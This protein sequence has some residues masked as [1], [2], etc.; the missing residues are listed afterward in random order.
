[1]TYRRPLPE[2]TLAAFASAVVTVFQP[3]PA[4]TVTVANGVAVG[5]FQR[6]ASWPVP[7]ARV[8]T[9]LMLSRL[10]GSNASQSP[11]PNEVTAPLADA[12]S[13]STVVMP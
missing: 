11:V 12:V 7:E 9:L 3:V 2:G 4:G 5:L 8:V 13:S 1:M 10:T 6:S